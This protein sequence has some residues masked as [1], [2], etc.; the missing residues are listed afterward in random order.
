M[1]RVHIAGLGEER[2][3]DEKDEETVR[4]CGAVASP[5]RGEAEAPIRGEEGAPASMSCD[6]A[7]EGKYKRIGFTT[8]AC[9]SR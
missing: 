6:C 1:A 2:E 7:R 9:F 3:R 5:S 4:P 8:H